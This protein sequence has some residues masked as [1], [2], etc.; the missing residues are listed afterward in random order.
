MFEIWKDLIEVWFLMVF[1]AAP[2][3]NKNEKRGRCETFIFP[4]TVGGTPEACRRALWS[5]QSQAESC[6][7]CNESG[8]PCPLRAGGGGLLSLREFRRLYFL[9]PGAS[10]LR[11]FVKQPSFDSFVKNRPTM[12]P[13]SAQNATNL[14]QGGAARDTRKSTKI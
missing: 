7:V 5:L 3:I 11:S 4:G 2:K 13:H 6:R 12:A 14:A 8:A 9:R 1:G 10:D